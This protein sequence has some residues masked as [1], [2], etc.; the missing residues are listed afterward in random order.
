[1][2]TR[3]GRRA[4]PLNF[5]VYWL[6][7]VRFG[8]IVRSDIA[9]VSPSPSLTLP[10]LRPDT[11]QGFHFGANFLFAPAPTYEPAGLL[12]LQQALAETS[13][14]LVFDQTQRTPTGIALI[15]QGPPLHVTVGLVGPGIGQ[16]LIAAP[17]P[18]RALVSFI[19]DAEMVVQAYRRVWPGPIQLVRRD[20]T[21]RYLYAVREGHAMQFLWERRLHQTESALSALGRPVLGG[22]LRLVMPARPNVADD[23]SVEVKIESF[24]PDSR[25]LFL[26]TQFVWESLAPPGT[27][28]DPR[29]LIEAVDSFNDGALTAFVAGDG[30]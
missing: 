5:T 17:Q 30:S 15:R 3:G 25:Q 20:C 26:E 12:Q 1:M 23:A 21:L 7:V 18:N 10:P 24:L 16:L 27:E 14:A 4:K 6:T 13:G 29:P 9:S 19:E 8:I 2:A 28:P 22:G 11:K